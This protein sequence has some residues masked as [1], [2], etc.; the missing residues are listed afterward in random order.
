MVEDAA[1][2]REKTWL[3]EER[4]RLLSEK[5]CCFSRG[6][7][8]KE[9]KQETVFME[10][11]DVK[12]KIHECKQFI[13]K[14]RTSSKQMQTTKEQRQKELAVLGKRN[15]SACSSRKGLQE[16]IIRLTNYSKSS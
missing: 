5:V 7:E 4:I 3:L 8:R 11:A 16:D 14:V 1:R 6:L 10:V 15:E 13:E 12:W 2:Q 9:K